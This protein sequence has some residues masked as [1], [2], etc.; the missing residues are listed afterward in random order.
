[1]SVSGSDAVGTPTSRHMTASIRDPLSR[2]QPAA[3]HLRRSRLVRPVLARRARLAAAQ[4][5]SPRVGREQPAEPDRRAG[6]FISQPGP[7]APC[8][9]RCGCSSTRAFGL[10]DPQKRNRRRP[11]R[12]RARATR[13]APASRSGRRSGGGRRRRAAARATSSSLLEL[14]V[15]DILDWLWEELEAAG[16]QAEESRRSGRRRSCAKAGTSAACARGS[17]AAAP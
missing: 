17:T 9:C 15:D 14:K 1:M 16:S 6:D 5:E 8:S 7:A 13:C 10:R 11:G 2:W 3:P 12:R 4:R